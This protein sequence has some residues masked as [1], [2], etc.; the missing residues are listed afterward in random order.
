MILVGSGFASV[1]T[2]KFSKLKKEENKKE[3]PKKIRVLNPPYVIY[4]LSRFV[5]C[6]LWI[7]K[8][9]SIN[10]KIPIK[11]IHSQD[12]GY[13][14]LAS[15]LLGKILRI[16]VIIS[17]HGIRH[18]TLEPS[19]RGKLS[20]IILK[21]EYSIDIFTV[22]R[23][24]FV[25]AVD[26][27][28]QRYYQELTQKKISQIPIALRL[29]DFKFSPANRELIRN[30]FK[31]KNSMMWVGYVGRLS[32]EKNLLALL[33]AFASIKNNYVKLLIVGK[34]PDEKE[35]KNFV[36]IKKIEDDVI[37]C[38]VRNDIGKILS[39]LDVFVL[40]SLTEGLPTAL[41]EAMASGRAIICSN[42]KAN[43][44]LI[45]D[46]IEGLL[47]D[48]NKQ[49]VFA[50]AISLLCKDDSLRETLGNNAKIKAS[51]Y[52]E[53][54]IFPQILNLYEDALKLKNV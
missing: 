22:K 12:T 17:S 53:E 47:V 15:I 21:I 29:S 46:K 36:K 13:A 26:P 24:N 10:K 20:K 9:V 54:K 44:E 16:P 50:Q 34:G 28:T 42:I 18:K 19:L 45:K 3:S 8:I 48:P 33:N 14:G 37:F 23:A 43:Q 52:D 38:G 4:M 7:I 35:L 31:I 11:L 41:I 32:P 1:R 2:K 27:I 5:L 51:R 6:F 40:P 39:A 30:E 25:I 49:E